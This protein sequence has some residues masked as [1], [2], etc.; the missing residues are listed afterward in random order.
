MLSSFQ[1]IDFSPT[2]LN[3][4]AYQISPSAFRTWSDVQ[5]SQGVMGMHT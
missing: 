1:K 3:F 2:D 4:T 5:T